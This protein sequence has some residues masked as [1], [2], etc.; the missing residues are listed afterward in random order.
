M[1]FSIN[2]LTAILFGEGVAN[3]TGETLKQY[4]VGKVLFV[5]DQ[6][7][8]AAGITDKIIKNIKDNN[9]GVVEFDDVKPDPPS[10]TVDAAGNLARKEN[11]DAVLG[12]GGGSAMDTA[13]AV[14]VLL[15]NPGSIKDY[16]T[17]AP[18]KPGKLI[19]AMPTTAGTGSE[20]TN[21][22]VVSNIKEGLKQG[23]NH[24][25]CVPKLAIIDPELT[26]GLPPSLTAAGGMDAFSHAIESYTGGFTNPMSDLLSLEAIS[27]ITKYLPVAVKD[28]SNT[29]A[30]SKLSF[31]STIAGM[32]FNDAPVH[33]GHALAHAMGAVHHV[34]HGIGCGLALP[35][36]MEF[37]AGFAPERVRGVG[38]AM[39]LEIPADA[40]NEEIGKAVADAI[41]NINKETGMPEI[42]ALGFNEDDL[43]G[44][45]HEATRDIC[46]TVFMPKKT[47]EGEALDLFKKEFSA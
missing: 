4:G 1:P 47:E 20:V 34:P 5:Y 42:S 45:V 26:Y 21:V 35:I 24:V 16:L 46:W 18:Q 28:G 15:G 8:K 30:R 27:L 32:A 10:A 2:H 11:V 22:A 6:G 23:I 13:K 40:A 29:E 31:A 17:G 43:P 25:N 9:I 19:F 44:I 7:L 12:I 41:R 39:G 37:A 38:K 33:L 14:N 3:Q 36:A